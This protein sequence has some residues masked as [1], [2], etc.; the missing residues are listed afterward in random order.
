M[1]NDTQIKSRDRV[2]NLA[3][4]YTNER[5]V[6]AM[7]DLVEDYSYQVNKSFLE[8]ACGNGNFLIEIL[9][10]KLKTI[11]SLKTIKERKDERHFQLFAMK[12]LSKIYGLDICSEN[13]QESRD[14]LKNRIVEVY[15]YK[16]SVLFVPEEFIANINY[17]LER[18]IQVANALETENIEF[19]DFR[20]TDKFYFTENVFKY[21]DIENER[22][23]PRKIFETKY[24]LEL[25][26]NK[27]EIE[28]LSEKDL[29]VFLKDFMMDYILSNELNEEGELLVNLSYLL[30]QEVY[31]H[32]NRISC[33]Y[34]SKTFFKKNI[35]VDTIEKLF[36]SIEKAKGFELY[37][38]KKRR[39]KKTD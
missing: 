19:S 37:K 35:L 21:S 7:L 34:N 36:I 15:K 4:V 24:F 5:E 30:L 23:T 6:N 18:N 20:I 27:N 22:E 39:L 2:K 28:L 3:E 33:L 32:K 10:R 31:F 1:K 13:I 38:K 25:Y 12:A 11:L 14:R 17:I 9:N 16:F 8:P 29:T 26:E